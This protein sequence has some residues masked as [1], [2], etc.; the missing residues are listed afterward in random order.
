[1]ATSASPANTDGKKK[2]K[3]KVVVDNRGG[4][5]AKDSKSDKDGKN[6]NGKDHHQPHIELSLS[7]SS[8][9]EIIQQEPQPQQQKTASRG[10][11]RGT[12]DA[13][14]SGSPHVAHYYVVVGVQHGRALIPYE[15]PTSSSS[16]NLHP[17]EKAG[18]FFDW[19]DLYPF[20]YLIFLCNYMYSEDIMCRDLYLWFLANLP[21]CAAE[22]TPLTVPFKATV[23]SRYPEDDRADVKLPPHTW[24]V[25]LSATS[26]STNTLNLADDNAVLI[27][28]YYKKLLLFAPSSIY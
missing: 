4:D 15:G 18:M 13:T 12:S 2:E 25:W 28:N 19:F 7:L 27:L 26:R 17:F 6:N 24:M 8:D 11:G 14:T 20:A 23:L 3:A 9:E 1:M 22:E 16:A 10:R 21:R 5:K